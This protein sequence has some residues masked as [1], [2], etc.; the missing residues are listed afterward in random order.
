MIALAQTRPKVRMEESASRDAKIAAARMIGVAQRK[1]TRV[2][3]SKKTQR[4][5][6]V[7]G[8]LCAD[9]DC[10]GCFR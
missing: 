5:S 4:G 6:E 10:E 3:A 7:R 8:M 1:L 9:R 2:G